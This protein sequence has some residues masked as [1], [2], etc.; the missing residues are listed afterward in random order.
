MEIGQVLWMLI[1]SLFSGLIGVVVSA[2][3]YAR[4]ER[5]KSKFETLR[6]FSGNRFD[7]R[8][9]EFSRVINEIFV[10]F[11]GSDEVINALQDYLEGILEKRASN[12]L[13]I[14]LF[15]KMCDDVGLPY[16]DLNDSFF[17]TPFNNRP[18]SESNDTD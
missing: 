9:V 6:R 7:V 5:R 13:L 17:L 1:A 4:Y 8:N 18:T 3:Y 15:K 10:V 14:K 11:N 16:K 12:D 2:C